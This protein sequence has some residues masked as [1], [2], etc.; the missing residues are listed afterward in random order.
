[1]TILLIVLIIT[2]RVTILVSV[3]V[4]SSAVIIGCRLC[5][6][7]S[8]ADVFVSDPVLAPFQ[9]L[10]A[11]VAVVALVLMDRVFVAVPVG[12]RQIFVAGRA[13]HAVTDKNV[14]LLELQS[15]GL[16]MV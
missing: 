10:A 11:F 5:L 16:A 2:T 13:Q 4:S 8:V 6:H 14:P 15:S 7:L 1:M 12:V 9:R 3:A